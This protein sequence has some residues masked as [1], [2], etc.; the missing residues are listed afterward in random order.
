MCSCLIRRSFA[1]RG[2]LALVERRD[3]EVPLTFRAFK[4][5]GP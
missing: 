1:Y 2:L 5:F 4:L 3:L